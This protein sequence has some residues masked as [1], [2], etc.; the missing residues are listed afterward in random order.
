LTYESTRIGLTDA[1]PQR[2]IDY[3]NTFGASTN[4]Y[5]GTVGWSRDSRDSAIYTTEGTTQRAFLESGLPVANGLR[6]NKLTYQQQWFYPVSHDVTFAFNGDAGIGDGYGGKPLPFFKNFYAGGVGSVRGYDPSSLGPV[7]AFGFAT[8]GNRRVVGNI[9]LLFPF[10]GMSKERSIRASTFVDG[11]AIYGPIVQ[12]IMP[13]MLGMRYS[14]GLA[15]TWIS[16]VGPL[17]FSL[18][19]PIKP[20]PGDKLQKL[21]FTL[22]SLF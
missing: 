8:G 7:D 14:Y 10:P 6:Y 5:M 13:Q 2:F 15:F 16:P 12:N 20:Q 21:Q 4:N 18:G 1:S 17:K 11:G 22:G 3:V 9:E 19:F